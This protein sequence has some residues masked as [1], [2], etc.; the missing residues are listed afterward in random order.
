M[1]QRMKE[2]ELFKEWESQEDQVCL[3]NE[4]SPLTL[5]LSFGLPLHYRYVMFSGGKYLPN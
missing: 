5:S 1:L 4:L 2:A 3:V